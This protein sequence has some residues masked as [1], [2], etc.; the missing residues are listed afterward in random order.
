MLLRALVAAHRARPP[1]NILAS[2]LL[3][4]ATD[5]G[6]DLSAKTIGLLRPILAALRPGNEEDREFSE[7]L[8]QRFLRVQ[9]EKSPDHDDEPTIDEE[10]T[11]RRWQ[12]AVREKILQA[13]SWVPEK[14]LRTSASILHSRA[15]TAAK[16]TRHE[17]PDEARSRYMQAED[18]LIAALEMDS[19]SR[20]DNPAF[21]LNT[22]GGVYVHWARM[23]REHGDPQGRVSELSELAEDTLREAKAKQLDS[24]YP[25]YYLAL[26]KVETARDLLKVGSDAHADEVGACLA[27]AL[28]LLSA[29]PEPRFR[30]QW[31]E[32]FA[33]AVGLLGEEGRSVI[34]SLKE[35][36][37]HLGWALE[38]LHVLNG[39]FPRERS[40]EVGEPELEAA[41]QL[42]EESFHSGKGDPPPIAHLLRYSVF[43]VRDARLSEPAYDVRLRHLEPVVGTKYYDDEPV[44]QF[45]YGMLLF[46][47]GDFERGADV[48]RELRR[49]QRF[50][51]VPNDRATT[52]TQ[53]PNSLVPR[54]FQMQVQ[55]VDSRT[56][57]GWARVGYPQRFP[58]PVPFVVRAFEGR[59]Y[60][61]KPRG[62]LPCN[63]SVRPAGP[64]AEPVVTKR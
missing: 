57:Q 31:D 45:D 63:I 24:A 62:T 39:E 7:Q 41:W 33:K 52:L 50:F 28:E 17:R 42:I 18:D 46:Q 15:I 51:Y 54:E 27:E 1:V 64:F 22:L 37:K 61:I 29:E 40:P 35:R 9:R 30:T 49:G 12:W 10:K 25:L 59:D 48:F 3:D 14:L 20:S 47:N 2:A 23:E 6:Q 8:V 58:T 56:G 53:G 11:F 5:A 21:M 44:L 60:Q 55:N 36:G 34:Q 32:L 19:E 38:A 4:E 26:H 43:S 16:C 13:F